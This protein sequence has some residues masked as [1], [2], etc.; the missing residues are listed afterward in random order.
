V[1][2]VRNYGSV[3]FTSYEL[4]FNIEYVNQ[5]RTLAFFGDTL[6]LESGIN[7]VQVFVNGIQAK[8]TL[9]YIVK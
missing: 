3:P 1:K 5:G 2:Q 7:N 4:S 9:T 8:R 6:P